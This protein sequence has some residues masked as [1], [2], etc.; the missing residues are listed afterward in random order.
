M[1]EYSKIVAVARRWGWGRTAFLLVLFLLV[2]QF[3]TFD[4]ALVL[5]LLAVILEHIVFKERVWLHQKG[6]PPPAVS[7]EGRRRG[8]RS[9]RSYF[10]TA[11]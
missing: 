6:P 9:L 2:K 8:A 7:R 11:K 10:R 1:N 4:Q 3:V 5:I